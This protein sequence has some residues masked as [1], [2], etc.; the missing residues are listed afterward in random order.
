MLRNA[1]VLSVDFNPSINS[2]IVEFKD[3]TG[4]YSHAIAPIGAFIVKENSNI[5]LYQNESICYKGFDTIV[6]RSF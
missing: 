4:T 2:Y 5:I 6:V 3:T 1:I